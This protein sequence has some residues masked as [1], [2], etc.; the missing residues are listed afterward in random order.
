M[1]FTFDFYVLTER[2]ELSIHIQAL[3][4][5]SNVYTTSTTQAYNRLSKILM[6]VFDFQ[7][8]IFCRRMNFYSRYNYFVMDI[9]FSVT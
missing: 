9:D 2:F 6:N 5:K 7:S 1:Y 8:N 4:F 3:D